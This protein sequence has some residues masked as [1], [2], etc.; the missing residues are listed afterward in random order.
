MNFIQNNIMK[1]NGKLLPVNAGFISGT[2]N[3]IKEFIKIYDTKFNEIIERNYYH[4]DETIF[5]EI[6]NQTETIQIIY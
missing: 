4:D 6:F 5:G 2:K 1:Y 3:N